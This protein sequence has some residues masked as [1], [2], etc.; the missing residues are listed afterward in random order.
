MFINLAS[1]IA[2]Y[3]SNNK[4]Q[5][6]KFY[7]TNASIFVNVFDYKPAWPNPRSAASNGGGG[8]RRASSSERHQQHEC[9]HAHIHRRNC[10]ILHIHLD[11][12]TFTRITR[13]IRD[14]FE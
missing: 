3:F 7:T 5:Y 11:E 1:C 2:N 14:F 12:G 10:Y 6:L 13:E 9:H 8:T 4:P